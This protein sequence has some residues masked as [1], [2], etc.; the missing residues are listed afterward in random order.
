MPTLAAE[1]PAA[2]QAAT[3][4]AVAIPPAATTG[5]STM[6]RTSASS[7]SSATWPRIRPPPSMPCTQTR[8]Q[9]ASAAALASATDPACQEARAPPSW[10]RATSA[11]S[12]SP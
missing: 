2:R 6:S 12:G 7:G 11:G 9:P 3:P 4:R 10:T 1:A 8:S 5:T